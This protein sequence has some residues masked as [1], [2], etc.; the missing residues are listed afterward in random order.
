MTQLAIQHMPVRDFCLNANQCFASI[1]V[2]VDPDVLVRVDRDYVAHLP[3]FWNSQSLLSSGQTCLVFNHLDMQWK[4]KACYVC[5]VSLLSR[6]R[7][8]L[9][10]VADTPCDSAL[11]VR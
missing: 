3:Y 8:L 11:L 6:A 7:I 4:W 1:H 9:T 2:L 10:Y 5:H